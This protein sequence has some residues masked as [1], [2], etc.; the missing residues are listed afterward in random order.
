MKVSD[1][2]EDDHFPTLVH[3]ALAAL[4]GVNADKSHGIVS[5]CGSR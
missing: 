1:L 3:D 4:K 5:G 2:V